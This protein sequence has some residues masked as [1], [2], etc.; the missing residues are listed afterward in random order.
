[1]MP[2]GGKTPSLSNKLEIMLG[3]Y[4]QQSTKLGVILDFDGTLSALAMTPGLAFICPQSK[5][6]L[7][8]LSNMAD[9]HVAIISGRN[10]EDLQAKVGV[11]GLTYAGNHGLEIMHPDGQKYTH[12]IPQNYTDRLQNLKADLEAEA[13]KVEGAWV[14]D[15][16]LL[17]ALHYR[18]VDRFNLQ[19]LLSRGKSIYARYNFEYL[20][21]SKRIENCPP[22]GYDRGDTCIHILRSLYGVDWEERVRI[23]YV[24]DSAADEFAISRLKGV[25]VT[26]RVTNEDSEAITKTS[27]DYWIAGGL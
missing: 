1:M 27:A 4:V 7:E 16:G 19:S 8:H 15:K 6:S 12:D 20:T 5:K 3:P 22:E 9:V 2:F 14:E 21:V 25:A 18:Q 11:D 24:G 23:I 26:F 13:A 10:L 17:I